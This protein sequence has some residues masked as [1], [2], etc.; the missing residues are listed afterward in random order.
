[1]LPFKVTPN[2]QDLVKMATRRGRHRQPCF[3]V[4]ILAAVAEESD[5]VSM[6][7]STA[8]VLAMT[9]T[10]CSGTDGDILH[11]RVDARPQPE[12]LA[13]WQIQLTGNLDTTVDVRV[14]IADAGTPTSVIADLHAAGR[15]VICYFSA[16]TQ[17]PFRGDAA[18]FPA[19]S[20]G[21]PVASYPDERWIDVRDP[22]VR[23]IMQDRITAAAAGGCDGIEASGLAAFAAT[24][25]FDFTRADQV[26][27]DR[28]LAA[29]V[30][31]AGLSLGFVEN[32]ASLG[33]DLLA[34]FDWTIVWSCLATGCPV[35]APYV[36]AGKPAFLVEYGDETRAPVVCPGGRALG[37]SAIIKRDSNLD[38]FRVGCP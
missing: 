38:A 5:G 25:G 37:M 32:D 20:L 26:G 34:D 1:M 21:E 17:E 35:A 6:R 13:S 28:W 31:R 23:A 27:Y 10:A 12:S 15:I 18:R 7:S 4:A 8:L 19:A 9:V 22:T 3:S 36:A 14:F 29:A 30:H 33:G 24:T 16:G 2:R 11:T